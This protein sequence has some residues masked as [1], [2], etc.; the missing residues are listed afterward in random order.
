MLRTSLFSALGVVLMLTGPA[1]AR[2]PADSSPTPNIVEA[3]WPGWSG[4]PGRPEWADRRE[5]C[6]RLR[7][8]MHE[9]G[10]RMQFAPP[11][12]RERM[13]FRLHEVRERLRHECWRD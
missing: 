6:E 3:Q 7:H 13:G 2:P 11:W 8:A 4:G 12:E 9:I 1:H 10:E 5:D